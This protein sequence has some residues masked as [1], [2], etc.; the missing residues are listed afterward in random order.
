MARLMEEAGADCIHCSQGVYAS[1]HTIIPP[2]VFPRAG[3]VENA[4]EMKKAVKIPVIVEKDGETFTIKDV[5]T[6][7]VAVGVRLDRTLLDHVE[8]L[9]CKVLKVGDANGVKNGY[10]GIREGF[11]AE[12]QA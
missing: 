1:T 11:E 5:D 12:L 4:A 3:Y 7:I 10:L 6:V 9:S 2:S 8:N